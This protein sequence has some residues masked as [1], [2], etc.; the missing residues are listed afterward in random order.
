[1]TGLVN[2]RCGDIIGVGGVSIVAGGV[3]VVV[4]GDVAVDGSGV[5]VIVVVV[6]VEG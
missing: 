1:M 2:S 6:S 4:V 3:A 5:V